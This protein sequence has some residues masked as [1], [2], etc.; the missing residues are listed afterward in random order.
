MDKKQHTNKTIEAENAMLKKRILKL[1]SENAALQLI[2]GLP[3]KPL[4]Y[5]SCILDNVPLAILT[6]DLNGNMQIGNLSFMK[7]F[8]LS[9]GILN[10][11][12][13]INQFI[14]LINTN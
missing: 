13:N 5:Y 2:N 12:T 7:L 9:N 4:S 1:E 6:L 11:N 3:D 14:Y 8:D 10:G